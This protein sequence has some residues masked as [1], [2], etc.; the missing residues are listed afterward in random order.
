M[1]CRRST[2]ADSVPG[3]SIHEISVDELEAALNDSGDGIRI[4]DVRETDEYAGG[5]VP[6][7]VHVALGTV[8][9]HVDAF[10]GPG[11]TY[12]ICKTGARSRRACEFLAE[13]GVDAVNVAG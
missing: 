3:M 9:E 8:P 7:A 4:V 11:T 2:A 6:G 5:H 10:Q 1:I 12:V 13:R